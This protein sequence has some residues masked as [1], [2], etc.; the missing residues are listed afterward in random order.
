MRIP[1]AGSRHFGVTTLEMLRKHDVEVARV[2]VAD[3][4]DRLFAAA[5][6]AWIGMTG[7][8]APTRCGARR[9]YLC[10]GPSRPEACR[11]AGN[12]QWHRPDRDRPQPRPR[13][14]GG[15]RRCT[16]G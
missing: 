11:C 6:G 2:V 14:P 9:G 16:V 4:E 8:G 10:H 3:A 12:R 7:R 15:A 5:P 1:L 13:E